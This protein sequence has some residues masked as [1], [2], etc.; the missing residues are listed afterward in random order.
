MVQAHAGS[1]FSD[2]DLAQIVSIFN[3]LDAPF[4]V[5]EREGG[6]IYLNPALEALLEHC[7][8]TPSTV[9]LHEWLDTGEV[10][11]PFLPSGEVDLRALPFLGKV[12]LKSQSWDVE[13]VEALARIETWANASTAR[14]AVLCTIL[15]YPRPSLLPSPAPLLRRWKSRIE[16][17]GDSFDIARVG[18]KTCKI[19]EDLTQAHAVVFYWLHAAR[20]ADG[21][22][23]M[24]RAEQIGQV[25]FLAGT[26]HEL[27]VREDWIQ[28]AA[29]EGILE[30]P[31]LKRAIKTR[32]QKQPPSWLAG[33]GDG[34]VLA[35]KTRGDL[36]GLAIAW[37]DTKR[38]DL[39]GLGDLLDQISSQAAQAVDHARWFQFA[40]QSESRGAQMIENANAIML[41]MDLQGRITLW[42]RK[43]REVF[44]YDTPEILGKTVFGLFGPE[45]TQRERARDRFRAAL[46][47]GETLTDFE[48]VMADKTGGVRHVIW[49][50]GVLNAPDGTILGLCAVGQDVTRRKELERRLALSE[51]R[52][53]NLVETTHD[54]YWVLL[55][56]DP[57]DLDRGEVAFLNRAFAGRDREAIVGRGIEPFK[58]TFRPGNWEPFEKAC[59]E[60][61]RT[62]RPVQRVETEH[63]G[64]GE[65]PSSVYMMHDLFPC[66][67]GDLLVG[68]QGLSIDVTRHKEIEAQMLQ[69]QKLESVGT[70]ARGIAHDFNNILNGI[71][72]FTFMIQRRSEEPDTV[73]QGIRAIQDLVQRAGGLTRQLQ[74]Y[75]RQGR[76]EKRPL[77]LNEILRQAVKILEAG[78]ARHVAIQPDLDENLEWIE[79]D[80]SQIEQVAMNLCI[81]A[82]EAMPDGGTL[83][84]RTRAVTLDRSDPILPANAE[85]GPYSLL[86]VTDTGVGMTPQVKAR[87]FD[88][89]YTTKKT[90][91]GLGLSAVYGILKAHQAL[92]RVDSEVG[93]GSSFSLYFPAVAAKRTFLGETGAAQVRGGNET[94]LVVDDEKP[95]RVVCRDILSSLGYRVV[96][97]AD[98]EAAV[99]IFQE[100]PQA[101]DLVL[102]DIA[103][104]NLNGCAAAKAMR[105]LYPGVKIL[106]T[107]G[108]TDKAQIE[109]LEQDGFP[110][111][112]GKPYSMLD[113]QETVRKILDA[114]PGATQ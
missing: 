83:S 40:R 28:L 9:R 97:A 47:T 109:A 67:E 94:I 91:N 6:F 24:L 43:A 7:G 13:S 19:I 39:A 21:G 80:R 58:E 108:Y 113:L 45:E 79:A 64:A 10:P 18:A 55:F 52:Y 103:M 71:N 8:R 93:V 2:P 3:S 41:G 88:P 56:K 96:L 104:P 65:T 82:A 35:C 63:V 89:F 42:N 16:E 69:A 81:N 100:R 73:L 12:R 62:E 36:L 110:H 87:I 5:A 4:G 29:R 114:K 75:A 53:R 76:S 86:Q 33:S 101:I 31:G 66:Y 51:R 32:D 106:F 102:M 23:E 14:H 25:R 90:G 22:G 99:R 61:L 48:T 85:G 111:F 54:L 57:V 72:G 50:T 112:L 46:S 38:L 1:D 17:I 68:V 92:V 74:T 107:S 60:V 37:T 34:F 11:S 27:D 98:G 84:V 15:P 44:G 30:L 105:M 26:P 78:V 49:N 70:L 59:K 20:S 77:D 95:V